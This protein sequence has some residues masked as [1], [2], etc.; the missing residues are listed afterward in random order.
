M[1]DRVTPRK[2]MRDELVR[3]VR[4]LTGQP[5]AILADLPAP[6]PEPETAVAEPAPA[7][8][9]P[10]KAKEAEKAAPASEDG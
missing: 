10:A 8:E 7:P 2:A 9:K 1:I 3:I 6:E 4:M 5:P